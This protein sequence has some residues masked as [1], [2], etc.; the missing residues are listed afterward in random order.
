MEC[1]VLGALIKFG[2]EQHVRVR[3]ARKCQGQDQRYKALSE[4]A[5]HSQN[6]VH[7]VFNRVLVGFIWWATFFD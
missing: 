3:E 6:D 4:A 2:G 5:R 7:A 1:T